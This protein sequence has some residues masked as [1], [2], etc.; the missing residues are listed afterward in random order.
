M[1][2]VRELPQPDVVP[3][4]LV[5]EQ[6]VGTASIKPTMD[7]VLEY[8]TKQAD[9]YLREKASHIPDEQQDEIRQE[10][11]IRVAKAYPDLDVALGWKS[12]VQF[13]AKGAIKDYLRAG[14]GFKESGWVDP[15]PDEPDESSPPEGEEDASNEDPKTEMDETAEEALDGPR[16]TGR[17]L[18]PQARKKFK[19]RL[20][21]R[22]SVISSDDDSA[23][24]VGDLA[25]LFGIHSGPKESGIFN[26][27]WDLIAR[28][29]AV[30]PEIL[31]IAKTLRGFSQTDMAEGFGVT[32]ERLSQRIRLFRDKLD[33]PQFY[34]SA[35]VRQTLYA[36]GLEEFYHVPLKERGDQN[37]GWEN[38]PIDLDSPECEALM[39]LF[40]QEEFRF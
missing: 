24:D 15:T 35:W 6:K 11:L 20:H 36:F 2:F 14:A 13:H 21:Q 40:F 29:S 8:A 37:C 34:H 9:K 22:V 30:D 38:E 26:P 25:G 19:Q 32:R 39:T 18:P 5:M 4:I 7:E 27:N 12:F 16:P 33:D 28:M 23:L 31:L 10:A 3:I 1:M 17:A